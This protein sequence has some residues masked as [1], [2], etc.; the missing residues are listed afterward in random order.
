MKVLVIKIY[1]HKMEITGKYIY[2]DNF[3]Y[4]GKFL[5]KYFNIL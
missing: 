2:N 5:V 3:F 4:K 1:L